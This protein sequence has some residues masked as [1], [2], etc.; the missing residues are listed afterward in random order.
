MQYTISKNIYHL[1][2]LN[3][4]C[5]TP[6]FTPSTVFKSWL[7]TQTFVTLYKHPLKVGCHTRQN[8]CGFFRDAVLRFVSGSQRPEYESH[9]SYDAGR[10]PSGNY[11]SIT[12]A[13]TTQG[14]LLSH[15]AKTDIGS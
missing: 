12:S 9:F 11:Q 6:V 14:T 13:A 10:P 2:T 4:L 5:S 1:S 3:I 8:R 15:A 7:Y